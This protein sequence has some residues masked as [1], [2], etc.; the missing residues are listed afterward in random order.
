MTSFPLTS[1]NDLPE[2]SFIAGSNQELSFN[3]YDSG[4]VAVN[5]SGGTVT[6]RLSSYG[7]GTALVS[8]SGLLSGSPTNQFKVLL[9]AADTTSLYGKFIQQ[10]SLVDTSGSSFRPSQGLINITRGIS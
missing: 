2:I 8:K 10:Y 6:W 1:P 3:V 4:S 7:Q 5:L 9:V